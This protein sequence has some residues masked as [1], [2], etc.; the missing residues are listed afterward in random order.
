MYVRRN[1]SS[2]ILVVCFFLWFDEISVFE[3]GKKSH[4][5]SITRK[6]MVAESI[7]FRDGWLLEVKRK[8]EEESV[9][10][11]SRNGRVRVFS[12]EVT[13]K[14]E[15][16]LEDE[17]I[18]TQSLSCSRLQKTRDKIEVVDVV[19]ST[20]H[21]VFLANRFPRLISLPTSAIFVS[22]TSGITAILEYRSVNPIRVTP[23]AE[24]L[25]AEKVGVQF[26]PSV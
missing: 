6:R 18:Y 7:H 23:S 21:V 17:S 19:V 3:A 2:P 22:G 12:L 20:N 5:K 26:L 11:V 15:W 13:M 10:S 25:S 24:M 4:R 16:V 9:D 14:R 8:K 1:V